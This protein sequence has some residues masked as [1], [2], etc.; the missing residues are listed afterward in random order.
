MSLQVVKRE[1][2]TVTGKERKTKG[3]SNW[4]VG[5]ERPPPGRLHMD[6][7]HIEGIT[8]A[9]LGPSRTRPQAQMVEKNT[10][11]VSKQPLGRRVPP[12]SNLHPPSPLGAFLVLSG[13][14]KAAC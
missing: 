12:V 2:E 11:K 10:Y 7:G 4:M 3:S 14:G 13:G 9:S 1:G 6:Q 8:S 5:R